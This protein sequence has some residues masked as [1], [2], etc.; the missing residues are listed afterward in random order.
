MNLLVLLGYILVAIGLY[1]LAVTGGK[2]P[3]GWITLVIGA[4]ILYNKRN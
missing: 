2:C 1:R 4:V 3:G